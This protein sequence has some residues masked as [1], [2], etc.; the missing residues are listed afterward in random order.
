VLK[1]A[2]ATEAGGAVR[3]ERVCR[4]AACGHQLALLRDRIE[5]EGAASRRFVN[6]LGIEYEIAG[7]RDA[8][9]CTLAGERSAYWIWFAGYDWQAA[10]CGACAGH[11]GWSFSSAAS[12]FFGLIVEKIVL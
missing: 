12:R 10:L 2:P 8:A 6:P 1:E 7:F 5:V 9:G 3:E 4:C 11:V